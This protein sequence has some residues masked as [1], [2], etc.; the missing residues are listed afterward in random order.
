MEKGQIS[1]VKAK[2]VILLCALVTNPRPRYTRS[3]LHIRIYP[4]SDAPQAKLC[5]QRKG[6]EGY[7]TRSA[8]DVYQ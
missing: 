7:G 8:S 1:K 4:S 6:A 2:K 5:V 3:V